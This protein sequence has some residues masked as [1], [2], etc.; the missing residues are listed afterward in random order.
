MPTRVQGHGQTSMG[1]VHDKEAAMEQGERIVCELKVHGAC[2][3][4]RD[5]L[6][7]PP[8]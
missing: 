5:A 3:W 2:N 1:H 6:V 8:A 7:A 4:I